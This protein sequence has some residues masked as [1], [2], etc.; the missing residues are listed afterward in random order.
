MCAAGRFVEHLSGLIYLLGLP[1]YLRDHVAFEDVCQNETG[2][3][4]HLTNA[5]WR[6]RNLTD[7]DL[8]V[9]HGEIGEIVYKDGTASAFARII[10]SA[11]SGL[12]KES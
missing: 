5:S 7:R 11:G 2:M 12:R 10:L 8:P 4:M 3:V 1:R 9:I 6:V